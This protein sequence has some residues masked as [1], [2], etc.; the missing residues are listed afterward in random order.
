MPSTGSATPC[1][2]SF[3]AAS[4]AVFTLAELA[5]VYDGAERWLHRVVGERAAPNG[6]ARTLSIASDAA[7][8]VYSVGAKDYEP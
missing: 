7:F 4:A 6:W 1:S 2:K 5:E 8:D 3:T